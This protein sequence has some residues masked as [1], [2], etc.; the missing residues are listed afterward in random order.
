MLLI[1]RKIVELQ[2][3][4]IDGML[5]LFSNISFVRR[6]IEQVAPS[7]KLLH[8]VVFKSQLGIRTRLEVRT[9]AYRL[10]LQLRHFRVAVIVMIIARAIAVLAKHIQSCPLI[11]RHQ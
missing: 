9:E 3:T 7:A 11:I 5:Q 1:G 8:V 2:S 10:I 6:A 4:A